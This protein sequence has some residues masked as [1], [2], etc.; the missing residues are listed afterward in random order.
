MASQTSDPVLVAAAGLLQRLPW[1]LFGLHAG[2]LADRLDRRAIMVFANLARAA[3]LML[4]AG[5]ILTG[6]VTVWVVLVAMFLLGTAETFVDIT[7]GTLLPMIVTPDQLGVANARLSVGH[8]TMNQLAG[9]PVGAALFAAGVASPFVA[10]AL[11]VTFGALILTR[12]PFGRQAPEPATGGSSW[13]D[14]VEGARW[15]WNHGAIRTLTLTVLT[16]NVTFG[17]T[18]AIEVLYA[19]QRLGLDEFGFGLLLT[20]SAVGGIIGSSAY[21]PLERRLGMANL[22]RIGLLIETAT[23]LT[24]ALTTLPAVAMSVLVMFGVHESVWYVTVSTIRQRAVPA[25]LQGRVGSVYMLALMGGLVVGSALGGVIARIW[26]ITAPFWF[27]FVG[28][29]LILAL[30]WRRLDN[31]AH[32]EQPEEAT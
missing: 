18:V 21:A 15:L 22:M 2:V 5:A 8:I 6:S 19:E 17:A 7:A 31:I 3:V 14:I 26:G 4:L 27:A 11:L 32:A 28:S 29:M 24:L 9:P 10:Q 16:F 1:V 23:H 13:A 12:V 30:I 20:A 25:D